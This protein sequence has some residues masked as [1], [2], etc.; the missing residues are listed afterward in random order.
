MPDHRSAYL[1]GKI[2]AWILREGKVED[3][4][5]DRMEDHIKVL[6]Y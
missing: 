5:Q 4:L 2:T 1:T 3:G 6:G